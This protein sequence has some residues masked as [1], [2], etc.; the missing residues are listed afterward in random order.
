MLNFLCLPLESMISSSEW[1][2]MLYM[3]VGC[4][5]HRLW[6]FIWKGPS[7][8]YHSE[9][10]EDF[11]ILQEESSSCLQFLC[12]GWM[13]KRCWVPISPRD[14]WDRG[15]IPAEHQRSLLWVCDFILPTELRY[16]L[17]VLSA[18][19]CITSHWEVVYS[20][21]IIIYVLKLLRTQKPQ[22]GFRHWGILVYW[23][24][25]NACLHLHSSIKG[26]VYC[27]FMCP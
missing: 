25:L 8:W 6:L 14:A 9:A 4:S 21:S 24:Y 19:L 16:M 12:E 22:I 18:S 5:W 27:Q 11:S 7:K 23:I 10:S 26:L 17:L 15:V 20:W 3:Y 13:Y 2:L 1:K